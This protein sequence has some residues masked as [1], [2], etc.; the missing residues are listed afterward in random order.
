MKILPSFYPNTIWILPL[1]HSE[2]PQLK[3][4]N[5]QKKNKNVSIS[6]TIKKKKK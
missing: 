3:I 4:I 1:S 2:E 5:F 6:F